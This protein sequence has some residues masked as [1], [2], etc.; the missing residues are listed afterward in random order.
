MNERRKALYYFEL[1]G[2][3]CGV[4]AMTPEEIRRGEGYNNVQRIRLAT[5]QD[6]DWI[7]AMGGYVPSEGFVRK[8][9][10]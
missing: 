8:E 2:G 6:V 10:A 7:K 1:V 5:Q 4:R 9:K 3:N